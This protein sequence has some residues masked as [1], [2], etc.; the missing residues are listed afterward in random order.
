DQLDR[1]AGAAYHLPGALRLHGLLNREALRATLDRLV[2]RH[3]IL[4]TRFESAE[5]GQAQQVIAPAETG[6][7]LAEE[8]LRGV[9]EE[10]REQ[11]GKEGKEGEAGGG[12]GVGKGPLIRGRLLQLGEEEYLLLVTQHHIISDGWSLGVLVG[13][14]RELYGAFSQ[15]QA[16][17]LPELGWQYAD[18]AVWQREWLQGEELEEQ[19]G[20]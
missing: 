7:A 6:F 12:W 13:E 1:A 2:A 5:D 20:F 8:D 17:P 18:Y 16:D 9:S 4:R 3:E 19:L 11:A 10:E 14:V 15:G